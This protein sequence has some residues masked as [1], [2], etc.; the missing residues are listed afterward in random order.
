MTGIVLTEFLEMGEDRLTP[1][2]AAR[3]LT[4]AVVPSG[5]AYTA[6]GMYDYHEIIP[7]RVHYAHQHPH[8]GAPRLVHRDDI[9]HDH[10]THILFVLKKQGTIF[11]DQPT[12]LPHE[13]G[14]HDG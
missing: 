6:I 9:S 8:L 4:A 1:A 14:R 12:L 13:E 5:S 10:G 11:G 2:V 7:R 3:L